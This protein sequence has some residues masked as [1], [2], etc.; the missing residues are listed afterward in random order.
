MQKTRI[1]YA[2]V[3]NEKAKFLSYNSRFK[4]QEIFSTNPRLTTQINLVAVV[5]FLSIQASSIVVQA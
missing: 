2:A 5:R 4:R 1:Y 3:F